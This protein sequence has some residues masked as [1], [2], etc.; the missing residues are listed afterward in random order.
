MAHNYKHHPSATHLPVG[1]HPDR[2]SHPAHTA[3]RVGYA[4]EPPAQLSGGFSAFLRRW[5]LPPVAAA[6]TAVA[7]VTVMAALS[8]RGADPAALIPLLAPVATATASLVGGIV[9]GLCHRHRATAVALLYGGG[10]TLILCLAGLATGQGIPM[11]WLT[12]LIPLPLCGL[13]GWL[14]RPRPPKAAHRR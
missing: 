11:A 1:K 2:L 8:A 10:L 5:L 14:V 6:V 7:A 9:A 3:G 13:G 4:E 12:R